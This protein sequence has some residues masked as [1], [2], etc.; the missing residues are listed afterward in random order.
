MS[1]MLGCRFERVSG[2]MRSEASVYLW[3][4]WLRW[5]VVIMDVAT[6]V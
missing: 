6:L 2:G 5:Y 1:I 3:V 4:Q